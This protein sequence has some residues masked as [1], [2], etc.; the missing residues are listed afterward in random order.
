MITRNS[1]HLGLGF[2]AAAFL[3]GAPAW[4]GTPAAPDRNARSENIG[5]ATGLAVGAAAGGPIGAVIGAAAGGLLGDRYHRNEAERARLAANVTE[6][7]G[8]LAESRSYGAQLEHTLSAVDAVGMDVSFRTD[9]SSIQ[10][11]DVGPLLKLGALAASV[12]DAK[13]RI[14]GFADPRGAAAYNEALSQRRAEAVAAAL[15]CGGMS[16]ERLIVEAHGASE[17][18]SAAGDLDAYALDRRV[19]VR[20]ERGPTAAPATTAARTGA[21]APGGG[22]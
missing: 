14:A 15:V 19:T 5:I 22:P 6:L 20:L 7:N 3:G 11:E 4:A 1:G 12:P 18:T 9:D 17:S 8:S 2:A 13:L 10:V 16:R 21:E